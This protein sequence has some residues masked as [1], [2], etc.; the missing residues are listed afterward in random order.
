[1]GYELDRVCSAIPSG[2]MSAGF[3]ADDFLLDAADKWFS[4]KMSDE[5]VLHA[6][7]NGLKGFVQAW[8]GVR[9]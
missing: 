1:E 9:S 7:A 6:A 4:Q 5:E 3:I 8:K 2:C